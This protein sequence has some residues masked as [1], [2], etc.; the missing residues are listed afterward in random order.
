MY[1]LPS[2]HSSTTRKL[3]HCRY[4]ADPHPEPSSSPT[5]KPPRSHIPFLHLTAPPPTPPATVSAIASAKGD[6]GSTV[7]SAQEIWTMAYTSLRKWTTTNCTRNPS[8]TSPA[9]YPTTA[10]RTPHS[11]SRNVCTTSIRTRRIKIKR[12]GQKHSSRRSQSTNMKSVGTC[13]WMGSET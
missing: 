13:Y 1:V 3:T 11:R 7:V 8:T 4:R 9:S 2:L 6:T 5:T 10:F 12:R